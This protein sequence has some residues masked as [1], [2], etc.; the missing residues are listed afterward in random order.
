[1]G[2]SG[3]RYRQRVAEGLCGNCGLRP[4]RDGSRSNCLVCYESVKRSVAGSKDGTARKTPRLPAVSSS[5]YLNR[6]AAGKCPKCCKPSAGDERGL[7]GN[8]KSKSSARWK[9]SRIAR[10]AYKQKR[11]ALKRQALGSYTARE[12][13]AVVSQQHGRCADCGEKCALT[14]DHIIPLSR[15]GSN[16]IFNIQGLCFSCNSRK[17]NKISPGA[18]HSLFDVVP[19]VDDAQ[20]GDVCRDPSAPYVCMSSARL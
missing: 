14:V 20:D 6:I 19:D 8:C 5:R 3:D 18:Q 15:G 4:L 13:R 17:N 11:R 16:Y 2:A 10:R 7:C 1:M 12:W 9:C